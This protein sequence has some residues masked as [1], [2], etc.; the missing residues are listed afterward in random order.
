MQDTATINKLIGKAG[1][2]ETLLFYDIC[3]CHNRCTNNDEISEDGYFS[4][5]YYSSEEKFGIGKKEFNKL[6]TNLQNL[7]LIEISGKNLI[8]INLSNFFC[9]TT[10]Y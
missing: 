10:S 8:R 1:I 7:S 3:S 2:R 4:Y 5:N 6:L 9:F